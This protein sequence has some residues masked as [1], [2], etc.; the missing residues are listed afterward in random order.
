[1]VK[2]KQE[3]RALKA[4][5]VASLI[6]ALEAF[7][8]PR[9]D[10]RTT[11]VLL[12]L[13]H[14]FE[15]LLKAALVQS[16]INV[17]DRQTGRSW[18]FEACVRH[19]Q[20]LPKLKLSDADAGTLRAVDALRDDEQ[21]WFNVV[22]EQLLYLHVRAAVTLYLLQRA[23]GESIAMHLPL[24]VLPVT[25]DP[26]QELSLVL[27]DE[28]TQIASL[29]RPG[30]RARHEARARIRT[31]LAM[32]AHVEPEAG[33][34]NRDVDRVEQGIKTGE[35]RAVVFPKLNEIATAIDGSGVGL[36]V[37][38]VKNEAAP[39]VRYEAD[40]T[41]PAA[42]IREV[43]LQRKFRRSP[44]QLAD[45]LSLSTPRST[46]LRQHLGID[47]DPNCCYVFEFGSQRHPR[48]SDNAFTRMRQAIKELDMEAVWQAHKP[49]GRASSRPKCAVA[50][51]T[52]A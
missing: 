9:D 31:L 7:N 14:S 22:S 40:E 13:Q 27:D 29:L 33:V 17:F 46:A 19:A 35:N 41:Q 8:S 42:A 28:Y 1:V 4:K 34:S 26:P 16:N 32:E 37:R 5:A 18:G 43:D 45:D 6:T 44:K 25:I 49:S 20:S 51:C 30:R 48:Y 38:F 50:G 15:M 52:A 24:R 3:A 23:F 21:H 47:Q 2:L 36:T 11:K 12:H 39:P 10:G